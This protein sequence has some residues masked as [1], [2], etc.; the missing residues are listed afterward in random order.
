MPPIFMIMEKER[1][2]GRQLLW[3]LDNTVALFCFIKGCSGNHAVERAVQAFHTAAYA[4]QTNA[5]FEFV[6]SAQNWADGISREGRED[7]FWQ[8]N[9]FSFREVQVPTALWRCSLPTMWSSQGGLDSS[10]A[11]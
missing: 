3:F 10:M 1:L 2:W 4:T 11:L 7:P 8:E 6:P 9:G 5:W